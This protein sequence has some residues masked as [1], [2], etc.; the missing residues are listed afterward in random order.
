MDRRGEGQSKMLGKCT[1]IYLLSLRTAVT[2]F[3]DAGAKGLQTTFPRFLP[4]GFLLNS[5][6]EKL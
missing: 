4:A 5:A 3:S 2:L 1:V 6:S